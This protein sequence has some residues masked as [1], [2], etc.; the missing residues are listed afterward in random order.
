MFIARTDA[1]AE[2]PIL[3]PPHVKSWLIGKDPDAGRDWGQEEKGTTEDEMAGWHHWLDGR[4]SEWTPGVGDGQGGLACCDSWDGKESDTTER[5]NWTE[6]NCKRKRA[7]TQSNRAGRPV[8]GALTPCKDCRAQ[9]EEKTLFPGKAWASEK[10]RTLFYCPN[11]L[12]LPIK[13]F[14][15]LCQAWTFTW[16]RPKIVMLRWFWI[17]PCLLDK[18]LAGCF[19][20]TLWIKINSSFPVE[21]P[22][23]HPLTNRSRLTS[24]EISPVV[25]TC[26]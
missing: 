3:W 5:L 20:L 4:E 1:E 13:A 26:P 9:Q 22:S 2:T 21:K 18:Y 16:C 8:G 12:L 17:I 7:E 25:I 14:F 6:L 19:S 11:F 10:P 23:R 24:L 15:F